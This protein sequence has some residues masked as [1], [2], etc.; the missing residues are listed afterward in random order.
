M[1]KRLLSLLLII[2]LCLSLIPVSPVFAADSNTD[3]QISSM[4]A[5]GKISNWAMNDLVVGD[6]Y[7]FYPLEW[8]NL[9]MTAPISEERFMDLMAGF[10]CKIVESKCVKE[11]PDVE[12]PTSQKMTVDKVLKCYYTLIDSMKFDKEINMKGKTVASKMKA[13]G[14]YKGTNGEPKLTDRCSIEAACVYATR[15]ITYIYDKLDAGSKGFFWKTKSGKTTVYML[16]SIHLASTSIYPFSSQVRDAYNKADGLAVEL[17]AFDYTGALSLQQLGKY[18]DGTT[19]KDHVTAD[20]YD[21]VMKIAALYGY[22]EA[23]IQ[24]Y[25]PWYIDAIFSSISYTDN[26]DSAEASRS[27]SLG[28]DMN[29]MINAYL[30]GKPILEI[31]G[32]EYQAKVLDSFSDKLDELLLNNT[33]D[34][35]NQAK[36]GESSA[37]EYL[38]IMLNLWHNGDTEGFK[39]YSSYDDNYDFTNVSEDEKA[40]IQEYNDKLLTQRNIGMADY[41]DQ[42]LKKDDGKTY[43]VVVGSAHYIGS[44]SVVDLLKQKGYEISQIK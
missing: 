34:S 7:G 14:I 5:N 28:I 43:F 10:R 21:K 30:S 35:V 19:L 8:D 9:N 4:A 1:K 31:E 36:S 12:Y 38:D 11:N 3:A 26:G 16:G 22:K 33:M 42:L 23:E 25:K 13:A 17:N 39:E 40:L 44:G 37:S 27:A 18:S 6:N 24:Q 29:F 20:T 2:F 15:M 41:I 32:Y